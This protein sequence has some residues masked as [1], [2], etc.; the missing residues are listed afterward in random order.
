MYREACARGLT[1]LAADLRFVLRRDASRPA[2]W[3]RLE[4]TVN[5][6]RRLWRRAM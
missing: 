6:R 2:W 1:R 3:T 4:Q 5:R